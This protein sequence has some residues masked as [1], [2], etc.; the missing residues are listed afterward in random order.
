MNQMPNSLPHVTLIVCKKVDADGGKLDLYGVS[1][2]ITVNSSTPNMPLVSVDLVVL[3]AV[4]STTKSWSHEGRLTIQLPSGNEIEAGTFKLRNQSGRFVGRV[5]VPFDF[6]FK[7]PGV[8]W[9][10]GYL[11]GALAARYPLW[12]RHESELVH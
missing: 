3:L 9:V 10:N 8:Y 2:L 4:F 11:D 6:E 1:D 12:V 5:I 7:K